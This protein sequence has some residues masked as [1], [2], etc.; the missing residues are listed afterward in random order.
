MSTSDD[1][2]V[3]DDAEEVLYRVDERT[4]HIENRIEDVASGVEDNRQDIDDIESKVKRNTT[5]LNAFTVGGI[6][7]TTWIADK[8][9]RIFP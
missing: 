1:D 9:T 4:K 7:V 2:G 5:I 8:L 6:A 3:P